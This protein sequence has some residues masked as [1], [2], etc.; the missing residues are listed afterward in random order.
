MSIEQ[1]QAQAIAHDLRSGMDG[2]FAADAAGKAQIVKEL[3]D[4]EIGNEPHAAI[5][6]IPGIPFLSAD[7][8]EGI[9]D[10]VLDQV[11]LVIVKKLG[12]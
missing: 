9:S 3:L 8:L 5:R 2:F 12:G 4:T 6:A 11:A 10:S 1:A 7:I